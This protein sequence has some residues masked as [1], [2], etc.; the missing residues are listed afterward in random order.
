MA[1]GAGCN[2]SE[3]HHVHHIL[4]SGLELTC[5]NHPCWS[6]DGR[7]M[8]N[9]NM[10]GL[11]IALGANA[12]IPLALNLQKL[13]HTQNNDA[14]GNPRKPMTRLP[15]WWVGLI[16]MISGEFFNLLAYGYAPTSLVAPVGAV[17]VFF[18]GI[19]ATL[20]MKEPFGVRDALGLLAIAGGVV[21]VVSAV[22]E[23]QMDLNN[24]MLWN[25]VLPD[26]RVRGY[27]IFVISFSLTWMVLIVPRYKERFVL[28]Y[29]TLCAVIASVTVV[30]SRTFSSI[31]TNALATGS[32]A[33]F[34]SPIPYLAALLIG[35][36]AVWSTAYLNAAMM[37]FDNNEVVP[38]YYCTFTLASVSAGAL[39]YSEFY[40]LT[41]ETTVLFSFGCA[42]TFFG[43]FCVA[44]GKPKPK[45]ATGTTFS[46]MVDDPVPVAPVSEIQPGVD[47]SYSPRASPKSCSHSAHTPS[48]D[49]AV[50]EQA[51]KADR[52]EAG[53]L[54][55]AVNGC[56]P[57]A[58]SLHSRS[59]LTDVEL[60]PIPPVSPSTCV[61]VP[62]VST[63][64][65]RENGPQ[66]DNAFHP[67][68]KPHEFSGSPTSS[69]RKL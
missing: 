65:S 6:T 29:L 56:L 30:A 38:V 28:C 67:E 4:P 41:A 12:V 57:A 39:V 18:N 1:E 54:G 17:G 10:I 31:L 51:S 59:Q 20:G 45:A 42:I 3:V 61:S 35:V 48:M 23:V 16:L 25:N 11:G 2:A 50:E 63:S 26:W 9:E 69:S 37:H 15:L 34:Q 32:F 21:M 64:S 68:G 14:D 27:F 44:S 46:R 40:C 47:K 8:S 13:A 7:T 62:S 19:I 55:L 36:T 22:P 58:T 53:D 24:E 33:E 49:P 43:V 60:A 66:V 5:V 52:L